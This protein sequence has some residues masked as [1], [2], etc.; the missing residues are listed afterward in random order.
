[1][2]RPSI[3]PALIVS[4]IVASGALAGSAAWAAAPPVSSPV[5]AGSASAPTS[6]TPGAPDTEAFDREIAAAKSSMMATPEVALAH[7]RRAAAA[8]LGASAPARLGALTAAWLQAEAL[9]RVQKP[10]QAL[11]ILD[12]T[13]P[14]II[15]LAPS[16]KLHGDALKAR[17]H[18]SRALGHVQAALVDYQQAYG[19]FQRANEPRSEALALQAIASVY[20]QARDDAQ[21]LRYYSQSA[22]IFSADQ[23]L[24]LAAHNNRGMVLRDLGRLPEALKEFQI[25][26]DLAGKL[27][28]ANLQAKILS[29]IAGADIRARQFASAQ[30]AIQRGLALGAN[31]DEAAG[32]RPFLLGQAASVAMKTGHP[33]EAG[34][35]L[36]QVF[37]G[38]DLAKTSSEF[39][40]AHEVAAQVYEATGDPG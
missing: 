12:S 16:T 25:A 14:A 19:I 17:G 4:A 28:S 11:A 26:F 6:T 9:E 22:D 30:A 24:S 38:V 40:D 1:M 5:G 10:D 20:Q 3:A 8:S 21:A 35:L 29:N 18:A 31:D 2:T 23:Q 39:R 34:R 27:D 7:A 15:Q 32:E 33:V 13:L 37:K 36:D